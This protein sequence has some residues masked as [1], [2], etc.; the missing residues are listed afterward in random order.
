VG[1]NL[2]VDPFPQN[3]AGEVPDFE[4]GKVPIP[5]ERDLPRTYPSEIGV[6]T[7]PG[8][9]ESAWSTEVKLYRSTKDRTRWFAFGA[10]IGWVSFPAEIAGWQKRQLARG[11]DPNDMREVPLRLGFNTGIPGAPILA[12]STADLPL[13]IVRPI[14]EHHRKKCKVVPITYVPKQRAAVVPARQGALVSD[15]D[16]E[17]V[18]LAYDLWLARGFRGGS[19]EEDL[20]AAV[21]QVK[22]TRFGGDAA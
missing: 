8:L 13:Q 3:L 6:R 5:T 2:R 7:L 15:S 10:E 11:A 18:D 20:L 16:R 21:R 12:G 19:P 14:A 4:I 9:L 1:C 22:G 17:V